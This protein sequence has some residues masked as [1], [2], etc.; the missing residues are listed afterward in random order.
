MASAF[1]ILLLNYLIGLLLIRHYS[2]KINGPIQKLAFE[3]SQNNN[4]LEVPDSPIEIRELAIN[5]NDLVERL[6]EKIESEKEFTTNLSHELRTP[7]MAISGYISLLKRRR[8]EHPEIVENA[9]DYLEKESERLKKLIEDFLTLSRNGQIDYQ[10][11]IF[12]IESLLL[13]VKSTFEFD[14]SNEIDIE[15]DGEIY[16]KTSKFALREI[17]TILIENAIKYS[18]DRT[19]VFIKYNKKEIQIIDEGVGIT[20]NEKTK[21][22]NRFYQVDKSR[23][24]HTGNGIGLAIA[25]QYAEIIKAKI[26]ITDNLPQGSIFHINFED[27]SGV[28]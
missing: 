11:E 7:V 2:K 20:D 9:L 13:E 14:S 17:L 21:V 8:V 15:G 23:G 22:L 25:Q 27:E 10:E 26:F 6:Q 1:V 19:R 4:L 28:S 3:A 16:I 18:P 5:F 12:T 24:S